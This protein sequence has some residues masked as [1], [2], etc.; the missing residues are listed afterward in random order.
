MPQAEE[1]IERAALVAE[2]RSWVGTPYHSGARVKRVGVDCLTVIVACFENAGLVA[3]IA[4]PRYPADWHLHRSEERYLDGVRVYCDEVEG[5]PLP[6]D[7]ALWRFGRC[8]AHG[9]I[10]T[11]WPRVVHAYVGKRVDEIDVTREPWLSQI[12]ENV[13]DKGKTRPMKV[14][15][16]RRWV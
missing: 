8:F 11:L 16:L 2:A 3:P 6:A 4:V 1:A 5:P 9:G 15:R 7:I 14:M 10:V 13:P 12:G